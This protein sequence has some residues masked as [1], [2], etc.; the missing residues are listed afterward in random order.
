MFFVFFF[1]FFFEALRN[2]CF[3]VDI[4]LSMSNLFISLHF[5]ICNIL[6][7]T[8]AILV[9]HINLHNE[10]DMYPSFHVVQSHF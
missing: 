3:D 2:N 4:M 6:Y 10:N 7:T 5:N 1:F 9:K 8:H